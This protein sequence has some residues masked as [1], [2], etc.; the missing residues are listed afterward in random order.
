VVWAPCI[1]MRAAH[2]LLGQNAEAR[3]AFDFRPPASIP[4]YNGNP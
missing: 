4:L 3:A 2:K 1:D